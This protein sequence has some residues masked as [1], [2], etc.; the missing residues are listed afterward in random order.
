MLTLADIQSTVNDLAAQLN[1][2]ANLLPTYGRT[3]DGARPHIEVEGGR[4][5]FIIV[6]RGEELE[7]YTTGDFGQLLRRIFSSVTSP[8]SYTYERAHRV[9]GQDIRRLAFSRQ[10]ELMAML[11]PQWAAHERRRHEEILGR[12]PFN[13]QDR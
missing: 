4:Y 6:E 9:A 2:P 5:H 11:D 12:H 13:D 8:M 3:D 10:V 1:A 7:R